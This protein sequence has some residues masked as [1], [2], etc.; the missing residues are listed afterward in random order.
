M[1]RKVLTSVTVL[2]AVV[3]LAAA[4]CADTGSTERDTVATTSDLYDKISELRRTKQTAQLRS[5]TDFNWD[6]VFCYYEGAPTDEINSAVGDVVEEPGHRLAVSGALAVFV[7]GGKPVR[8]AR[9]PEI[10]F[11]VRRYSNEVLVKEGFELTEPT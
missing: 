1:I 4:S 8:K 9:I 10:N 5:L 2:A 11:E 3:L 6:G 7:Q